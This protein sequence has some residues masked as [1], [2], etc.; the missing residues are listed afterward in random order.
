MFRKISDN[1]RSIVGSSPANSFSSAIVSP[2]SDA[3]SPPCCRLPNSR[4]ARASGNGL[5]ASACAASFAAASSASLVFRSYF[6]AAR[7]SRYAAR[8]YCGAVSPSVNTALPFPPAFPGADACVAS[9]IAPS[10]SVCVGRPISDASHS[11]TVFVKS[12]SL[13]EAFLY[14]SNRCSQ[15]DAGSATPSARLAFQSA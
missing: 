4:M 12:V 5:S 9:S 2:R 10:K 3:E 8:R 15:C 6:C 1:A 13:S 7:R 11:A 14:T